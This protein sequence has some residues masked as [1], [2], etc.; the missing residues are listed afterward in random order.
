M[1]ENSPFQKLSGRF[2]AILAFSLLLS[3]WPLSGRA[4][5]QA[6][7]GTNTSY[8]K[9]KYV[10]T[11]D[12]FYTHIASWTKVLAPFK[13]KE[14]VNYLEVGVLEGRAFLWM[15]E[16]ILT[17]PSARAT[18]IDIFPWPVIED[19]FRHNLALSGFAGKVTVRKGRSEVE[20]RKLPMDSFDIIYVDA[21]HLGKDVFIDAALSWG[22]LKKGGVLIFDDYGWTLEPRPEDRPKMAID[23]FLSVFNKEIRVIE[24]GYQVIVSRQK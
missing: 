12:H 18:G 20:L 13:D 15:L 3:L 1:R 5:D 6:S 21:S 23:A 24:L 17:A 7:I 14:G 11:A 8:Y 4:Q 10:F 2:P 19:R 16:N 9:K 22:L